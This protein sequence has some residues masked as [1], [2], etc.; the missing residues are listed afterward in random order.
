MTGPA[1]YTSESAA[2]PR[3][4]VNVLDETIDAHPQHLAIDNRP[5]R[6]TYAQLRDEI[7]G[8]AVTLRAAQI[9]NGDRVG[10]A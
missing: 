9:G 7:A 5:R 1:I 10:F 2:P 4:L 8:L 3:T 6:F